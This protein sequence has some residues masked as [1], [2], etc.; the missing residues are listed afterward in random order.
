MY[1]IVATEVLSVV[2]F[3]VSVDASV[4]EVYQIASLYIFIVIEHFPRLKN[5]LR[6]M[7]I[8]L[9][10]QLLTIPQIHRIEVNKLMENFSFDSHHIIF[11]KNILNL[12]ERLFG[13]LVVFQ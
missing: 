3:E 7:F 6:N 11:R 12:I 13:I 4:F 5:F 1:V 8:Q 10:L 9:F 2:E